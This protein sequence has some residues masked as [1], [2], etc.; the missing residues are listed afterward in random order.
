MV[1]F[2]QIT[3]GPHRVYRVN[4]SVCVF[5]KFKANCRI[6]LAIIPFE[7][8]VVVVETTTNDQHIT[9]VC[10]RNRDPTIGQPNF[11]IQQTSMLKGE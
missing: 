1:R 7:V 8:R 9:R 5:G 6:A 4:I 2:I 10:V 3:R 11:I